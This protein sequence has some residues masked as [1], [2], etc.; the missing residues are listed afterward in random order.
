MAKDHSLQVDQGALTWVMPLIADLLQIS[1][2]F[3][4]EWRSE[5]GEEA[6]ATATKRL[7]RQTWPQA[8]FEPLAPGGTRTSYT[9][10]VVVV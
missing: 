7:Q 8:V 10:S 9:V 5:A 1:H 6:P 4:K 3:T 2:D